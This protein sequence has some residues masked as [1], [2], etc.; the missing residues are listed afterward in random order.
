MEYGF[1][2]WNALRQH[3][4][5]LETP[6]A[7]ADGVL[8]RDAEPP[9]PELR[10][11][12]IAEAVALGSSD[13]HLEWKAGHLTVRQRVDGALRLSEVAIGEDQQTSVIDGFKMMAA[14]DTTVHD[15]SQV[16]YC[17]CDVDGRPSGMR[18]SAMPHT[19][20]E[21]I[22]VRHLVGEPAL[23]DLDAQRWPEPGLFTKH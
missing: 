16:G 17:T 6:T 19:S 15:E 11:A 18:V 23:F 7:E 3:V 2:D 5:S 14:L 8:A 1:K 22:A 9:W 10:R 12:I 13:T 4:E 20:G 21:P